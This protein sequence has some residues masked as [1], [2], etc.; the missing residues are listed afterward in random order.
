MAGEKDT[1]Q[2]RT[3][4]ATPRRKDDARKD[5]KVAKTQ[6]AAGALV[7]LAGTLLLA[8]VGGGA[9]SRFAFTSVAASATALRGGAMSGDSAFA[10][11][12]H[13]T[14][15]FALALAPFACGIALAGAGAHLAQTQGAMS[16]K[17][18]TPDLSRLMPTAGLKR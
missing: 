18:I 16:L 1:G 15:G 7:V 13:L 5:G 4:K 9:L 12:R 17:P 6:D 10:L 14:T 3:E 2:E 8:G 11:L